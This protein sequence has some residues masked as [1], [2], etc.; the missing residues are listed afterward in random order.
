M[1]GWIRRDILSYIIEETFWHNTLRL[2]KEEIIFPIKH[3][4]YVFD[5]LTN[6]PQFIEPSIY[7]TF[8][9]IFSK[10]I[11]KYQGHN[12]ELFNSCRGENSIMINENLVSYFPAL[13]YNGND[14]LTET[15]MN[16]ANCRSST[17]NLSTKQFEL[18]SA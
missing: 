3:N 14:V 8:N 12:K 4:E 16:P 18:C 10:Y 13:E 5:L 6:I 7:E 11:N 1:G 9:L 15:I 2:S 17:V